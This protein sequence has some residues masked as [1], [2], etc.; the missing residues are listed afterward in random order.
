MLTLIITASLVPSALFILWG[1]WRN[2]GRD[3]SRYAVTP[4]GLGHSGWGCGESSTAG[5]SSREAA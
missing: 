4:M 2:S 5:C 1:F 3:Q